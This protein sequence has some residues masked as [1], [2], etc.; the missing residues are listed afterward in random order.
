[1]Y[2]KVKVF[3]ESKKEEVFRESEDML[4]IRVKEKPSMGAANKRVREI[5]SSIFFGKRVEL[6]K[7]HKSKSKIFKINE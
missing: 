3:P 7:G 1:M 6:T 4:I 2:I 5:L